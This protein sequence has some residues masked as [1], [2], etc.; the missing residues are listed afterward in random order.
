MLILW[1]RITFEN[2]IKMKFFFLKN[3]VKSIQRHV[4]D[5]NRLS[6]KNVIETLT[7]S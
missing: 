1:L 6:I 3:P 2:L 4:L 7:N 5:N